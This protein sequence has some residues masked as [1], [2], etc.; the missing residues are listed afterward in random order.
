LGSL[1]ELPGLDT[2]D[3]SPEFEAELRDRLLAA[4]EARAAG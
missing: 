1:D 3:P 4:G 2:F